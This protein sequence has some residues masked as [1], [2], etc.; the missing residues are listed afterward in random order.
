MGYKKPSTKLTFYKAFFS[1]QWK[2]L[3]HMIVQC[4]SAKRTA[5]N[6]FSSSMASAVI[7]LATDDLSSYN[8]KYTSL[9]LIQ[10]V[11]ANMR[12]NGSS[13][14][15]LNKLMETCA[16]LTKKVVNLEQDKIAQAFKITKLKQRVKK[17]E[18]QRGFK[19]SGLKRLRKGGGIDE[20]DAD[21]NVTLVDVDTKVKM[22]AN[23]QRTMDT[24]EAEPAEVKEVLK[25]LIAT[26]LMKEVVTTVAHITT[27]A[28]VPKPNAPRKRRGVVIQD[29]EEIT[30]A[31]IIMHS[32][33]KSKD[34]E[35]EVTVQEEGSKR[36]GKGLKQDTTKKQRINEEA[37]ELKRHL[38]IVVNDDDDVF[39]EATPLASKLCYLL[40]NFD[41]E[42]LETLWKL[43]KERVYIITLTTTQMI[44]LVEKKYPLTHFTLEQM[45]NNMR[46]K[47][48]EESE[49]SLELLRRKLKLNFKDAQLTGPEL[50]HEITEK[51]VPI[52]KRIQADHDRQKSCTDVKRQP[53]EF[54]F[55]NRVMLKT[56][57]STRTKQVHNTFHVSNLKR[58][59]SNEPLDEIHI[60][61]KLN[62]IEEPIEIMDRE[63]QQLK[64]SRIPII[65][66]GWNSKRGPKFTWERE[67][68]FQKKYSH[69]FTKT[70]SSSGATS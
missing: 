62:F 47:V 33:V 17:L 12:R 26:K 37:E 8:T 23:L 54:K 40:R 70:A 55:R 15:L 39:T 41:I 57:T 14:N 27:A 51:I 28:Q 49:M 65:K 61:D 30:T 50:V 29:P 13:M 67:D 31:L 64:Q 36:K 2:F 4:I 24:N 7:C 56:Q 52:K 9:A 58:C 21:E 48:K 46:L 16:T 60:D 45:L 11:F 63:V 66:V 38:Q 59:S 53:L 22:D 5:W 3:I 43:A 25:V 1:A 10:K 42:D 19:S 69:L 6:E 20:L 34:K 35:E 44:L 18:K 32:E 68:Q